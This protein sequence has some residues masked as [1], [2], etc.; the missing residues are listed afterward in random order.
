MDQ[1]QWWWIVYLFN[2]VYFR[3]QC[4]VRSAALED[5]VTVSLIINMSIKVIIIITK[6]WWLIFIT[7]SFLVTINIIIIMVVTNFALQCHI[8]FGFSL[9]SI[10]DQKQPVW[11]KRQS[12]GK[13]PIYLFILSQNNFHD[14][15]Y[16]NWLYIMDNG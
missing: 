9:M 2:N 7:S 11:Q 4:G 1:S 8:R 6:T 15:N 5:P 3:L 16:C 13:L 14:N 12:S 10:L